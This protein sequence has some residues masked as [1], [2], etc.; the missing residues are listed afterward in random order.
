MTIMTQVILSATVMCCIVLVMSVGLIF[1][2]KPM[3]KS[4]GGIIGSDKSECG[5]CH[6]GDEPENC[7]D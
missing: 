3:Q 2:G 5:I 6:G 7:P 1:K 4:C